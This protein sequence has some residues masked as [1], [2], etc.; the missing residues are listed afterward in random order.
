MFLGYNNEIFG[1]VMNVIIDALL[2]TFEYRYDGRRRRLASD[3]PTDYPFNASFSTDHPLAT[4]QV[5]LPSPSCSQRRGR[6]QRN[7]ENA[8]QFHAILRP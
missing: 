7:N 3:R 4:N 2:E 5:P 1:L 8:C 6:H